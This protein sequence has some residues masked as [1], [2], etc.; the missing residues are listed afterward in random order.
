MSINYKKIISFLLLLFVSAAIEL[1][2]GT[3]TVEPTV[4]IKNLSRYPLTW[5]TSVTNDYANVDMDA[6]DGVLDSG[7]SNNPGSVAVHIK[8]TLINDTGKH[9]TCV[10]PA[11]RVVVASGLNQKTFT[12]ASQ[13]TC[14]KND[15]WVKV[16]GSSSEL[17]A[18]TDV[19]LT[20]ENTN[21]GVLLCGLSSDPTDGPSKMGISNNAHYVITV[22]NINEISSCP[23]A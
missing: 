8:G 12:F 9:E 17:P 3:K 16:A 19:K 21:E 13:V 1:F 23:S 5:G 2:A 15:T 11:W 22:Y 10:G 6:P 20:S 14:G 4:Y 18:P 7:S